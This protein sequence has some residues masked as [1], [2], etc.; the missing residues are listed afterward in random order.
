[1]F[2]LFVVGLFPI[3][4]SR[5]RFGSVITYMYRLLSIMFIFRMADCIDSG[6]KQDTTSDEYLDPSCD[7]CKSQ[8]IYVKV[9]SFCPTCVEYF[10]QDCDRA[11]ANF[12]I[13]KKH[14]LKHGLEMPSCEAD[15]PP[16]FQDCQIHAN[17]IRDWFCTDH[18]VMICSKCQDLHDKCLVKHA[19]V[20]RK[21]SSE[22]DLHKFA[23]EVSN[24]KDEASEILSGL[25]ENISKLETSRASM[26]ETVKIEYERIKSELERK[27]NTNCDEINKTCSEHVSSL[28]ARIT[29]LNATI[30]QY[31]S[32]LHNINQEKKT[33]LDTKLFV[34]MQTLVENVAESVKAVNELTKGIHLIDVEFIMDDTLNSFLSNDRNIGRVRETLSKSSYDASLHPISFPANADILF[35]EIY[36]SDV[37]VD[38]TYTTVA[39]E[40]GRYSTYSCAWMHALQSNVLDATDYGRPKAKLPTTV[41]IGPDRETLVA[42]GYEAREKYADL[43]GTDQNVDYYYF[44][45]VGKDLEQWF[46]KQHINNATMKDATGKSMSTMRVL[47]FVL[48]YMIDDLMHK[49]KPTN[50]TAWSDGI[51]MSVVVPSFSIDNAKIGVKDALITTGIPPRN[52]TI[53]SEVQAISKFCHAT[54]KAGKRRT[55]HGLVALGEDYVIVNFRDDNVEVIIS[56]YTEPSPDRVLIAQIRFGE[57]DINEAFEEFVQDLVGKDVFQ[58]HVKARPTDLQDLQDMFEQ[59]KRTLNTQ[60]DRITTILLT[61]GLRDKYEELKGQKLKDGIEQSKYNKDVRLVDDKLRVSSHLLKGFFDVP[62]IRT[63]MLLKHLQQTR[64]ADTFKCVFMTGDLSKISE[65]Q[66]AIEDAF[67]TLNLV[68]PRDVELTALEGA[69]I[70]THQRSMQ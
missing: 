11:H 56:K 40:I 60:T 17:A 9:A 13:T 48:N 5:A 45:N 33:K 41:L 22:N 44:D 66:R 31:N 55:E 2:C 50:I 38:R 42:F 35:Q 32:V 16:K 28:T 51:S 65:F 6:I 4:V 37:Y 8:K 52:I 36:F 39:I 46:R 67:P 68:F 58:A 27:Y 59:K 21:I 43:L 54:L 70:H 19:D 15:K 12:Q 62:V 61:C 18:N 23:D 63:C 29:S 7:P 3:L 49:L 25:E 30:E 1:M 14:R 26:L 24:C 57:S 64:H 20:M 69:I 10:C 53:I 47:T 34:K